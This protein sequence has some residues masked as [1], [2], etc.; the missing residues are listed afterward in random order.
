MPTPAAEQAD[1]AALRVR[2]KK[3]DDLDA[4]DENFSFGRLVG[5]GRRLLVD[6]AQAFRLDRTGFVDRLADHVH[7]AAERAVAH[8]NR[9][10]LAGV[11]HFLA[12]D[13]TFG[14]VHRDRAHCGLTEM[15]RNFQH[16][17][18]VAVLGLQ[19]IENGRQVALE[20][21]V[22]DSAHDLG[23]ATDL[24]SGCGHD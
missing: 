8:R 10:R 12:A 22:D 15:L 2:S 21:H 4:G 14:H 18:D 16:E 17:A 23:D 20:L 6:G 3:I 19:R 7:D 24:L 1:L 11:G 9:D 13:Q 5:V